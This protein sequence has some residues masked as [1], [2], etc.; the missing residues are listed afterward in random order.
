MS[1]PVPETPKILK[2]ETVR[3]RTFWCPFLSLKIWDFLV[4]E[5]WKFQV[6]KMPKFSISKNLVS[7][8]S[9]KTDL[10]TFSSFWT[11]VSWQIRSRIQAKFCLSGFEILTNLTEFENFWS[12]RSHDLEVPDFEKSM[13]PKS[14]KLKVRFRTLRSENC[15][16]MKLKR[17]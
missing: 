4:P 3:K 2:T 12:Q 14:R 9:K 1:V 17:S 13:F 5:I 10:P 8:L 6:P 16:K 7:I 11:K 15:P